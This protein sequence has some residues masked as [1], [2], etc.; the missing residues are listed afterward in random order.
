VSVA[1][2]KFTVVC[3]F[4]HVGSQL[5]LGDDDS[6]SIAPNNVIVGNLRGKRLQV[7]HGEKGTSTAR[8]CHPNGTF[9]FKAGDTIDYT[10]GM[11]NSQSGKLAYGVIPSSFLL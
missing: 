9:N 1:L 10:W 2:L 11:S 5:G 8:E 4:A 6:F 3:S 7:C